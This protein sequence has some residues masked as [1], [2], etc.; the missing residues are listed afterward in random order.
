MFGVRQAVSRLHVLNTSRA[1]LH[2]ST[3]S[4][5]GGHNVL[6]QFGPNHAACP[7]ST[8]SAT[9]A[10]IFI[11]KKVVRA[12]ALEI[13]EAIDQIPQPVQVFDESV[14]T[15]L[16]SIKHRNPFYVTTPIFYVNGEPHIGHLFTMLL[17]DVMCRWKRIN[18]YDAYLMCGTD[19][20]GAKVQE[21]SEKAG[22]DSPLPFCDSISSKFTKSWEDFG[23]HYDAFERTTR[24][25]HTETVQ[26][27]WSKLLANG[28]IYM[29]AHEGWYCRSDETFV[30][31]VQL[32][33]AE[34]GSMRTASGHTVEWI[35][36]DNY[37]FRLSAFT[38]PLLEW[39]RANPTAV[40]PSVR[41]NQVIAMLEQGLEDISVSRLASKLQWGIDVPADPLHKVY[42]W[43]DALNIYLTGA[44]AAH[45]KAL[46]NNVLDTLIG[47]ATQAASVEDAESNAFLDKSQPFW[48]AA[49]QLIGKDILK[50]HCIYWPAFL[51]GC[52]LPPPQQVVAHGHWTVDGMKMSKSLGNV[53]APHDLAAKYGVDSIR[54]ALLRIG[55]IR[56][57]VNFSNN[58]V[59]N[60]VNN[61]LN[62][63][64]GNLAMRSTSV[65]LL[66][67][68]I[69]PDPLTAFRS[70]SQGTHC[71]F[72]SIIVVLYRSSH[73]SYVFS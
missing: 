17:G 49:V 10:P 54:Y 26:W 52:G 18:G 53:L 58:D 62:D 47:N 9:G 39:L 32:V 29:G 69:Y 63:V 31:E 15:T 12:S 8:L 66:P 56:N 34:D 11:P 36:E 21:A 70:P 23:I 41:Y 20:H 7:K 5:V 35:S 68:E 33:K 16:S 60:I 6:S 44:K 43:L 30:P 72:D 37:K 19:E 46:H 64:I 45:D 25:E 28:H 65:A 51:M 40:T 73:C 24:P 14:R 1:N 13:N 42:V 22:F 50:F 61:E 57:D 2:T 4:R 71:L 48:P 27:M 67:S 3:L 38:A 59:V 55:N